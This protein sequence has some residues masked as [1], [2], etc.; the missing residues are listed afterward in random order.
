MDLGGLAVAYHMYIFPFGTGAWPALWVVDGNR[1]IIVFYLHEPR[2][3][4]NSHFPLLK[5]VKEQL[6]SA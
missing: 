5:N 3:K 4:E 6:P 2:I 1:Y